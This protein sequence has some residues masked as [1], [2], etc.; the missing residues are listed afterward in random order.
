MGL[1]HSPSRTFAAG[2]GCAARRAPLRPPFL[3]DGSRT[4]RMRAM[5]QDLPRA[6][7]PFDTRH[8]AVRGAADPVRDRRVDFSA[9]YRSS[10]EWRALNPVGKVPVL[11]DRR[12]HDVRI[13]RHGPAH[14]RLAPA[15]AARARARHTRAA[16]YLQWSWFAEATFARPIGEIVNHRRSFPGNEIPAVIEEMRGRAKLCADAVEAALAGRDYLLGNQLHRRR[17]HD[18]LH[19]DDLSP[20]GHARAAG[21]PR[22]LLVAPERAAGVR[23]T[24][25]ANER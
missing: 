1:R 17:H 19:A 10:P 5:M 24:M 11:A 14:P 12:L 16:I 23:A 15:D 13:R 6:R 7:N 21:E 25:A 4:A 8:L 2:G 3:I 18:G 9:E 20:T 22:A